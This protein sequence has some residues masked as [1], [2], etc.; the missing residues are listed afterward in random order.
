[1]LNN[2]IGVARERVQEALSRARLTTDP[3]IKR[4]SGTRR[5]LVGPAHEN[6]TARRG[7]AGKSAD[8]DPAGQAGLAAGPKAALVKAAV[9]LILG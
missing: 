5:R 3:D 8:R 9:V 6:G 4:L 7:A 2:D 1:M